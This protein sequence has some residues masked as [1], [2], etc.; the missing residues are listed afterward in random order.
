MTSE[1]KILVRTA[2]PIPFTCADGTGVEKGTIL[3]LTDPRTA[4][5]STAV[6]DML[7]GIAA[8]EKIASD[9]KTT[10]SAYDDCIAVMY[11]SGAC[12]VGKPVVSG[13]LNLVQEAG[14]VSGAAI[15]GY[16]LETGADGETILVRVRIGGGSI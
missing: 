6:G 4:S 5:A 2:H 14:A 16:A 1:A 9:G 15:L 11:L 12:A 7:A 3:K 13:G 8:K 10:I